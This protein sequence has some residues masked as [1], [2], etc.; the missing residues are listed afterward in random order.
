MTQCK[1]RT[2]K[3]QEKKTNHKESWSKFKSF[4][5]RKNKKERNLI[6]LQA[7][8]ILKKKE[9]PLAHMPVF[10]KMKSHALIATGQTLGGAIYKTV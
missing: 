5:L 4:M 3:D 7:G 6:S 8:K 2:K 10:T 9:N 1:M